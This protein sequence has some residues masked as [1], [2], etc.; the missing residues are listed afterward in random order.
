M[1]F[2]G[3]EGLLFFDKLET[4]RNGIMIPRYTTEEMGAVWS[5]LAKKHL[6][7]RVEWAVLKAKEKLGLIPKGISELAGDIKIDQEILNR[8]DE[9]ERISD[10]DLIAF[11]RAV[12][13]RITAAGEAHVRIKPYLHSGL[14][15]YDIEDTALAIQM[16]ESLSILSKGLNDLRSALK[17]QALAHRGTV[18]IGRTHG[19]HAEPITFGLKLLNWLDVIER[20]IIRLR[21]LDDVVAVG[22]ISGAVGAFVLDP[23]IE[24][25]TCK[26]LGLTPARSSTQVISRDIHVQ[27]VGALVGIANSLDRFAVNI[28]RMAGTDFG[29]VAEHKRPGAKGSSAMPGKSRLRNPIKSEN[30]SALARIMR[31]FLISA[32]ECEILWD[33][34]SLDNSAA[35]R[36]SLPDASILLDF[37][38]KRFIAIMES[39]EV[40]PEQMAANLRKTGGIVF[41]QRVMLALAETGIARDEAYDLVEGIAMM[42]ECGTFVDSEG[43]TFEQLVRQSPDITT[44]LSSDQIDRCFDPQ[45]S[46]KYVDRIYDRFGM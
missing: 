28:R 30:I 4:E 45:Q 35:E 29:E 1:A 12:T 37:M 34:R 31:G 19:I 10:H 15:S 42:V 17:R 46:L 43:R 9:L 16:R 40:Y 25:E 39:L 14:T 26:I 18:M 32:A 21:S 6:W 7:F 13:E 36:I 27:Y 11:I 8:A 41:A 33:E 3:R 23:K 24:E 20:H 2:F 5:E 38:L 22:K 44:R